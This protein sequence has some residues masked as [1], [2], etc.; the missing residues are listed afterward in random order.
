[1][2][3]S[4][5]DYIVI[6]VYLVG[7]AFLGL[8]SSGKQ[9]SNKDYFLGGEGIPWWAVLFSIVATETSTL[10]FISIPAVAYG[11]NLTFLQITV[12]YVIG[13]I[14]VALFF[15][16]KYYEG[17]LFTAYTFL[18]KRFGAGM[19]NAASSTFMITRLLAD[20]VRLFATA[21]PLAII[22]RLGGAFSGWGD[23]ELY[24]LSICVITAITLVYTFFGGIKAVVWMD[25]VQMI[26]YIG[27][28]LIAVG[29]LLGNLPAGFELPG[30]KLQL[31]N[32]GFD[33]SFRE[34]IAQPY[35][36]ITALVGGAVFSLASH[37]TDQLLV[38]RVLATRNLKS[39]QKAMIWS[40]IVAMLQFALFMGIGLLLYMFYEG[41]SAT[42]MG[43]ATTD[44]VFAK[45]IVEQLPVGVSGLIVAA[46]FAAAMSS[47]SSSLN[48]LASSTTYDLY[49]PY[50]GKNNT[51]AE[52]L[53]MS[54]KITMGWGIILT[55]SAV[56]FAILQL[57][58]GERPAIVELGLGIASYTY[59][60]LLGAFL[61]GMFF[62]KPDKTDALIGF[63]C[64]LI[65]LL[66]MVQGP[67]QNL[68]PGDGLAIAWPL[69]TLVGSLI[70]VITGSIS[71]IL[72][73]SK[74]A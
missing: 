15:L 71:A 25:F 50:F 47:L 68:L 73:G 43:L 14:G 34:F 58:G 53:S 70:V 27:G 20:G 62:S 18:E 17:E 24:I 4:V 32:L 30:E 39:G 56:F 45:F 65:A 29:V 72:R 41:V 5:I 38:Q 9:T 61:L 19:R 57:Q 44:E 13:R 40:G 1:M 36:L 7:V 35:T 48:S 11:G 51:E 64:G 55:A 74:H 54:R 6:V 3:F 26:V 59:G 42:E 52:D 49:K 37:G 31:V 63:F 28:A 66:F 8:K 10:T 23:L 67:I 46:L 22:L 16:P 12:G 69:Y 21:I 2:Q 33:M 60:G